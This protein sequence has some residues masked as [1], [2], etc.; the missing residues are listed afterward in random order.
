MLG[1]SDTGE[2]N[3]VPTL[4]RL[5]VAETDGGRQV[6]LLVMCAVERMTDS[7]RAWEEGW[8]ESHLWDWVLGS[9]IVFLW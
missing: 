6:F 4:R 8:E 9:G 5:L 1:A 2:R 7:W 3:E